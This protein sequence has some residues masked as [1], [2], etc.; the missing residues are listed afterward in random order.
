MIRDV[1]I[2]NNQG[3]TLFYQNFGQCHSFG[4][5]LDLFSG[6]M[7]AIQSFSKQITGGNIN[8]IEIS[9]KQWAF[10]KNN[11]YTYLI[12]AETEDD[13]EEI[14]I[15]TKK[16]SEIFENTYEAELNQFFGK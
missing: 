13:K 12:V 2:M 14:K 10:H 9:D 15:K 6:F 3:L 8:L 4:D 7:S 5:N 11:K 1:V 16:I